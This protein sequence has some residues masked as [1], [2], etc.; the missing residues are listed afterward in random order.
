MS[1]LTSAS[2]PVGN[3]TERLKIAIGATG[4][5]F[6]NEKIAWPGDNLAV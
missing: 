2:I 6:I 5:S 1:G 3:E 4:E